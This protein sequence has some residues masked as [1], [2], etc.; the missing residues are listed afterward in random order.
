MFFNQKKREL[1][2]INAFQNLFLDKKG[3]LKPE[4]EVVLSFLR[5]EAGARGELGAGGR[6]YFY[7]NHNKFDA[8]AAAFLLGKRRMFDLLVKYLAIDE[9]QVFRLTVDDNQ[10]DELERQLT[11]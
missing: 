11:V 4:G 1:K 3:Q 6:P 10:Q 9:R 2:L 8:H 7:D 5:D